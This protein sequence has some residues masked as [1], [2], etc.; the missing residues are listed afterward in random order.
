MRVGL[1]DHFTNC[2]KIRT[3]NINN[4][5]MH[6][7]HK[8]LHHRSYSSTFKVRAFIKRSAIRTAHAHVS[9]L[10]TLLSLL[11]CGSSFFT[12]SHGSIGVGCTLTIGHTYLWQ[13]HSHFESRGFQSLHDV[14]ARAETR[15]AH[16]GVYSRPRCCRRQFGRRLVTSLEELRN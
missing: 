3:G 12:A 2:H 8:P 7:C 4:L 11:L 15:R 10:I 6:F 5:T 9:R 13:R 1:I 16:I 14:P